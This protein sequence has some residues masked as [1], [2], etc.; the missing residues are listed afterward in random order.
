[1]ADLELNVAL[2]DQATRRKKSWRPR[3][4]LFS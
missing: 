3:Q 4:G 2:F 1:A